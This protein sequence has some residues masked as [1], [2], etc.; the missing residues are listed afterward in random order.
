MYSICRFR[1]IVGSYPR[2]ITVVGFTFKKRRFVQLHA[3]A[4]LLRKDAFSYVGVDPPATSGFDLKRM[5][6]WERRA[7]FS[8]FE[9]DPYGCHSK[10]LLKKRKDRNP[11]ARTPPYTLSCPEMSS[12]L[13]WCGPKRFKGKVPW[14]GST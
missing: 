1:E 12:L 5:T 7:S 2:K 8:Q 13:K 9:A 14:K 11:F 3:P 4:L 10:I 6:F